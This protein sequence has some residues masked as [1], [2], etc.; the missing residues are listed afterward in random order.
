MSILAA[1]GTFTAQ[2][3]CF[4]IPSEAPQFA[5]ES[6]CAVEGN[7]ATDPFAGLDVFLVAVRC[8]R[9]ELTSALPRT[10]ACLRY[11]SVL[12]QNT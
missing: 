9:T 3:T 7:T 10:T 5:C 6:G 11:D 4:V 1:S 8:H 12:N 2:P